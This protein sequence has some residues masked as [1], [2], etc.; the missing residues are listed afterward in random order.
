VPTLAPDHT[1]NR[2]AIGLPGAM[3]TCLVGP[4]AGWVGRIAVFAPV[5][6][7]ILVEVVDLGDFIR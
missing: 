2:Q 1:R 4:A 6:A 5:L 7:G 3:A